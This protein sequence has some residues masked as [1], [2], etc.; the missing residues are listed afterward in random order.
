M[1][2]TTVKCHSIIKGLA[3]GKALVTDKAFSFAHCLDPMTGQVTEEGHAWFGEDVKGKVL[4]FPFGKG[5]SLGGLYILQAAK[6]GN[7]P[8]AIINLETDPIITVGFLLSE[9]LYGI[10]VPIIDCPESNPVDVIKT[11]SW[12]KVDADKGVFEVS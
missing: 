7:L 5:S 3:E 9:I 4:V 12:V 2:K 8:V 6:R 11:G 10:K 1:N